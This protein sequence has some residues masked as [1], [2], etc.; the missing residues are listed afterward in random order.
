MKIQD[1]DNSTTN[2]KLA[3]FFSYIF[4]VTSIV[5]PVFFVALL[6]KKF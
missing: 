1:T 3:L 4:F 5:V 2:R 6:L